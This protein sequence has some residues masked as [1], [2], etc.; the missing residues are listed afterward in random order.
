MR[1][2]EL[3]NYYDLLNIDR[4]ISLLNV[5]WNSLRALI[6]QR[7]GSMFQLF[8]KKLSDNFAASF[9]FICFCLFIIK[10]TENAYHK[11]RRV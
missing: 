8:E 6:G 4:N 5:H 9:R 7:T 2:V 11:V 3:H 10:L 1:P